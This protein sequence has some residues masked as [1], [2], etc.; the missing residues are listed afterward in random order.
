MS[1]DT[2]SIEAS[3]SGAVSVAADVSGWAKPVRLWQPRNP[4]Y[5]LYVWLVANGALL[6][7]TGVSQA[8]VEQSSI[9]IAFV[10]NALYALIYVHFFARADRYERE[11]ARL[12]AL[13]FFFSGLVSTWLI[14]APANEALFSLYSK[15]FGVEWASE[16]G[17]SFAAPLTEETG[18]L[19]AVVIAALLA[20]QHVRNTY[21]GLLLGMFAGLGFQVFENMS[22]MTGSASGNFNSEPV[23]DMLGVFLMR[24]TSGLFGHWLWTAIAGAGVGYYLGNAHR[25]KAHRLMVAGLL[26]LAAMVAHGLFDAA[27]S[28]G[29]IALPLASA[30]GV[31]CF[32]LVLRFTER[33]TREFVS[34]L[35]ADDVAAGHV[36][37]EEL[38]Y[39][40]AG[41]RDRRRHLRDIKRNEGK[42]AARRAQWVMEAQN[43]LAAAIAAT[44]GPGSPEAAA[45]R[46]EIARLRSAPS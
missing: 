4:A 24:A 18:K 20:R 10:L 45:A 43:G 7:A 33:R 35:L 46:S 25:T 5:W 38:T 13:A 27:L 34:D 29:P 21:D 9:V 19:A 44:S 8:T 39:L 16:F 15:W 12:A 1:N 41:V 42:D 31:T 28:L 26:L 40:T 6:F 11:P 32:M 14:A 23:K 37:D 17:A 3:N 30:L 36:T 2:T 22:Y